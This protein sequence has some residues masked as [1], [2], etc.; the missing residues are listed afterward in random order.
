[1][2]QTAHRQQ[3]RR[4][5]SLLNTAPFRS[6]RRPAAPTAPLARPGLP[7]ASL[8]AQGAPTLPKG[9]GR[10]HPG[11]SVAPNTQ[12][13]Q[14]AQAAQARLPTPCVP[15]CVQAAR[16]SRSSTGC[17]PASPSSTTRSAHTRYA[18]AKPEPCPCHAHTMHVPCP[19]HAQ[20]MP[21]PCPHH[22]RTRSARTRA[23]P[24]VRASLA[25]PTGGAGPARSCGRAPRS[26]RG[27][28]RRARPMRT[29]STRGER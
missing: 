6:T 27:W 4:P 11:R 24:T 14:T 8:R 19:H 17:G 5:C 23:C 21:T 26:L 29:G 12:A 2:R 10:A 16:S 18:R 20:T 1:M 7:G 3:R 28:P 9:P 25:P 13:A 22:A 15:R